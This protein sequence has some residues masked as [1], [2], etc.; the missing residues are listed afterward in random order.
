MG[1]LSTSGKPKKPIKPT[2]GLSA[3]F[4]SS[5]SI[6]LM[7]SV[8][9]GVTMKMDVSTLGQKIG[10]LEVKDY[11]GGKG[12]NGQVGADCLMN[13][14]PAICNNSATVNIVANF[15]KMTDDLGEI[16]LKEWFPNGLT[17]MQT[18]TWMTDKQQELF[19]DMDGNILKGTHSDPPYMGYTTAFRPPNN[20][21]GA[22]DK[23][24]WY[25]TLEPTMI[26]GDVPPN[27]FGGTDQFIDRP[28]YPF[29][30]IPED[31]NGNGMLDPGEDRNGN[32]MLDVFEGLANLLNGKNGMLNFETVLVGVKE[33]PIDDP[34]T[35]ID[36]RLTE[37]YRVIPL[38]T[39]TWGLNFMFA[40]DGMP[41]FTAADYTVAAK[42]LTF[43]VDPSDAFKKA[44]D[45][46]GDNKDVEWN[47][48]FVE[49]AP[50]PLTMIASGLAV[51]FGVLCQREYSKKRR[52]K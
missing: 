29:Q 37:M 22:N 49:H 25:S 27:S 41:G 4:V 14:P 42:P 23:T 10:S 50:E 33:K 26:P 9:L 8:A 44:F 17:Y 12:L 38:K 21:P 34:T 11:V 35:Q 20:R 3:V 39:F 46:K 7:P 47:V 19:R 1:V 13:F 16:I 45:Q 18:V 24:P 31:L 15:T 5:L 32:G 6:L 2:T 48:K 51:G 40:D 30:D 36:E 28:G 43:S 52:K